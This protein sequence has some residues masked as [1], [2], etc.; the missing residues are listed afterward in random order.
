MMQ[1]K[2]AKVL[3]FRYHTVAKCLLVASVLALIW[4]PAVNHASEIGRSG[5]P[6]RPVHNV[7]MELAPLVCSANYPTRAR[8]RGIEGWVEVT[9]TIG[10][11]GRVT[12]VALRD[13]EPAGWFEQS[14]LRAAQRLRF[15]PE[16]IGGQPIMNARYVFYFPELEN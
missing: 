6:C 9:F 12:D 4:L 8:L 10:V 7:A 13:E 5:P 2:S 3:Q 11:D 1:I 16:L 14:S 15:D